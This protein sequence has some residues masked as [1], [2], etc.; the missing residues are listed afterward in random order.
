MDRHQIAKYKKDNL[1][2][3]YN[4]INQTDNNDAYLYYFDEDEL[5]FIQ[6]Y[7]NNST[8]SYKELLRMYNGQTKPPE[9]RALYHWL[10]ILGKE[11]TEGKNIKYHYDRKKF[12][13]I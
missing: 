8:S 7:L 5:S 9:R 2:Q 6:L 13:T 10:D 12:Q 1:Y 4:I 3:K 11:K